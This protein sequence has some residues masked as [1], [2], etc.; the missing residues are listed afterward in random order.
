MRDPDLA[1][2]PWT[3]DAVDTAPLHSKAVLGTFKSWLTDRPQSWR[4]GMEVV[5]ID[6]F[7]GFKT[8]T[9]EELLD[10]VAVMDPFHVVSLAG[11]A[12]DP[13]AATSSRTCMVTAAP[14]TLSTGPGPGGSDRALTPDCD[15]PRC[16]L[17][18]RMAVVSPATSLG[19]PGR[20]FCQ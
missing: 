10:A 2:A 19:P 9:T 11:D 5:A 3:R 13:A 8:P 7:T 1:A 6:G 14:R 17:V 20:G 15:E 4:A 18:S 12:L 16:L